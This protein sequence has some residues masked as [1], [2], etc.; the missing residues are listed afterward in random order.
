[1]TVWGWVF[2]LTSWAIILGVLTF[3]LRK[4]FKQDGNSAPDAGEE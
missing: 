4:T 1:M 3:C 2:M